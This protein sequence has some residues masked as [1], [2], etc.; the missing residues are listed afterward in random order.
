MKLYFLRH[1]E[2]I[3]NVNINSG[4]KD[5][6]LSE[7]GI[8]DCIKFFD[9]NYNQQFFPKEFDEIICSPLKR[10]RSTLEHL[11]I[12][13]KNITYNENIR[14]FKQDICD[15]YYEESIKLETEDEFNERIQ[16]FM[17]SLNEKN[18]DKILIVSHHDVIQ[19]ITSRKLNNL[20]WTSCDFIRINER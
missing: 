4:E 18:Y 14:E 10:T 8:K 20:E 19:C 2:S 16:F 1:A 11:P 6:E 15:Y 17:E 13:K 9:I 12:E 5:C 3:F 7:K